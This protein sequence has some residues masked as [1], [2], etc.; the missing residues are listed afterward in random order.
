M[1]NPRQLAYQS[2]VKWDT[3]ES[4]SN[5]EINTVL[6]RARLEKN[7]ASLYTLLYLGVLEKKLFLDTVIS[8]YSN[9]PVEEIDTETKNAVRLGLYQLIFTDRIPDYSAVDQSVSLAPKKSKGFVNAV[10]RSF[11]RAGKKITYPA[12]KW[13]RLSVEYSFPQELISLLRESYG[14]ETAEKMVAFT[15]TDRTV[16]IRVNTLK[17]STA[18]IMGELVKRGFEPIISPLAKDIIKCSLAVSEI[19]DL[20]DTGKAFIQDEAS[21]ICSIAVGAKR[22]DV[23]ADVCACPGGKTFSMA[24]DMENCGKISAS[25]LHKNK[26][27]LIEKG[28]AHLGIDIISVKEQNAKVRVSEYEKAFDRVLCD[29]PCSGLGVLYKKPEIKYKSVKDMLALP[30]VQ[31]SILKNCAEYVKVGGYLIYSTCTT[32]KAENEENVLRFLNENKDFE[33]ADFTVGAI[34]SQNGMYT[35]LPHITG[36]DG[37]F[38][39]KLKRIK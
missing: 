27:G 1:D 13:D 2:L 38:V 5:I 4:F 37:F 14:D 39:A 23:V 22:G 20:I 10:L 28:A 19:K 33:P 30:A 9:T 24:I 11:L 26:L 8:Q 18:E 6:S 35:F 36:T 25:D 12:D 15:D 32:R 3:Q 16:S 21:R 34:E 31:Y 29:V 7:D 17:C